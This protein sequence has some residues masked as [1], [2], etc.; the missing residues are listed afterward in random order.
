MYIKAK[1][2]KFCPYSVAM[3]QIILTV[4]D[5]YARWHLLQIKV[6]HYEVCQ[7]CL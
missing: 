5:T 3:W 2:L 1:E 6:A 7:R 4:T